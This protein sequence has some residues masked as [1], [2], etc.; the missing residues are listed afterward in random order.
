MK[1]ETALAI[2]GIA[3]LVVIQLSAFY[4]NVD[5]GILAT[6]VA[7]IAGLAGV[8]IGYKVKSK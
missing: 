8:G 7:I 6:T 3:A 4:Y 2:T 1:D 5:S